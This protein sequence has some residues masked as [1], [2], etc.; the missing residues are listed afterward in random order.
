MLHLLSLLLK[1]RLL[2]SKISA[3]FYALI[4]ILKVNLWFTTFRPDRRCHLFV[5]QQG[6]RQQNHTLKGSPKRRYNHE[7][8]AHFITYLSF[9]TSLIIAKVRFFVLKKSLNPFETI[10][11]NG[12]ETQLFGKLLFV[13]L[14]ARSSINC[15]MRVSKQINIL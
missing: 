11:Y 1:L 13:D 2:P 9:S 14:V 15:N 6:D 3:F 12:N 4:F 7:G 10:W 5:G 8:L